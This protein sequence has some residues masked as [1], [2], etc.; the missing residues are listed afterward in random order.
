MSGEK[1]VRITGCWVLGKRTNNLD[2][3]PFL[4]FI[5]NQDAAQCRFPA[6]PLKN[7]Q[8]DMHRDQ[9]QANESPPRPHDHVSTF[10]AHTA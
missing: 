4:F 9:N 1:H 7:C 2:C 10:A 5:E 8:L 3:P 6:E